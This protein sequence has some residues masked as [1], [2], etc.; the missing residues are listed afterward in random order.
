[1]RRQRAVKSSDMR[2]NESPESIMYISL[3]RIEISMSETDTV[4]RK[5][6][7]SPG[8]KSIRR[9][10][11]LMYAGDVHTQFSEG[12][13]M[14]LPSPSARSGMKMRA[15]FLN[16]PLSIGVVRIIKAHEQSEVLT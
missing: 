11:L 15:S 14:A 16:S 13:H 3:R 8:Y 1:M 6:S 9:G 4:S 5:K 10:I 12:T 2:S 7:S